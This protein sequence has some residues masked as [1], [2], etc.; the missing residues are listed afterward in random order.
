MAITKGLSILCED[1]QRTGGISQIFLR[2]WAAGD[3]A[4]FVNTAGVSHSISSI[5]DIGAATA[6]WFMFEFKDEVPTLAVAA[7][8]ENGSTAFECTLS[9]YLPRMNDTK[10]AVLQEMLTQCMMGIVVDTNG[11]KYVIGVSEKYSVGGSENPS[12]S[13]SQTY[14]NLAS[15]EGNTGAAYSEENGITITLMARQFELPR[16]YAG[17]APLGVLA[18]DVATQTATTT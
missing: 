8:K 13:R 4:T 17:T 3:E 9:F 1:L 10:F 16:L 7:T 2:S 11:N 5:V 15:M 6:D 12:L 18:P 14:L